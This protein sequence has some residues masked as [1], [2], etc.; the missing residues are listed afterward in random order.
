LSHTSINIGNRFL[1]GGEKLKSKDQGQKGKEVTLRGCGRTDD[2]DIDSSFVG[3]GCSEQA[4]R[5][6][7]FGKVLAKISSELGCDN[8]PCPDGFKCVAEI[9][10]PS[11]IELRVK[12]N[13]IQI[14][15]CPQQA[16]WKC[17]LQEAS[18]LAT[19]VRGMCSCAPKSL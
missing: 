16:G 8:G 9:V 6:D 5:N 1:E 17:F 14:S 7:L 10:G 19:R 18:G 13:R 11:D 4:A 15:N 3:F 12:C 2:F